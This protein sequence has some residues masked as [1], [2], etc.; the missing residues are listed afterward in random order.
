MNTYKNRS[1][2]LSREQGYDSQYSW[3]II[4]DKK[5]S[6][7]K[8]GCSTDCSSL[9]MDTE[10]YVNTEI[11]E[12]PTCNVRKKIGMY[13]SHVQ[14]HFSEYGYKALKFRTTKNWAMETVI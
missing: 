9:A 10:E 6:H 13:K 12:N 7:V 5:I 3:R 4:R 11:V 1:V 8:A 2:W 14:R